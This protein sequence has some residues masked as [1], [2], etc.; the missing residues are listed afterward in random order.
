MKHCLI[1]GYNWINLEYFHSFV[2]ILY[3]KGLCTPI[4]ALKVSGALTVHV[5]ELCF[6]FELLIDSLVGKIAH[7]ESVANT[8]DLN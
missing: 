4:F 8:L 7:I 5:R 2:V 6:M 3:C 1:I